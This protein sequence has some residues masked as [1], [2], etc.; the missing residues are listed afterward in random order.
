MSHQYF[1]NYGND[2]VQNRGKKKS[3]KCRYYLVAYRNNLI[4]TFLTDD[5]LFYPTSVMT[6][7]TFLLVHTYIAQGIKA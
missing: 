4:Q 2:K 1:S 3:M 6:D 5:K 7:N